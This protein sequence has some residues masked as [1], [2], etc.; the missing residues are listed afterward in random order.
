MFSCTKFHPTKYKTM[1]FL[2]ILLATNVSPVIADGFWSISCSTQGTSSWTTN[3]ADVIGP[4]ISYPNAVT[5]P[6]YTDLN[7]NSG[8]AY[9]YVVTA[10]NIS[11]ESKFSSEV[12]AVP[13]TIAPGFPPADDA[14]FISQSVPSNMTA[15]QTYN[16][17]V[18]VGN[19]GSSTWLAGGKYQLASQNPA[20]NAVWSVAPDGSQ[21]KGNSI[22]SS[23][24]VGINSDITFSFAVTAPSTPGTYNF[25]W[26]MA[27]ETGASYQYFGEQTDNVVITVGPAVA[28]HLT[29]AQA[30][31][32]AQAFCNSNGNPISVPGNAQYAVPDAADAYWQPCWT[33]TFDGQATVEVVDATSIVA[34]YMNDAYSG[35]LASIRQQ[36]AGP[37][38]SQNTAVQTAAAA[39]STTANVDQTGQVTAY[40]SQDNDG[41]HAGESTWNILYPRQFQGLPYKDDVVVM[42]IDAATNKLMGLSLTYRCVPPDNGG[43]AMVVTQAQANATAQSQINQSGIQAPLLQ[44]SIVQVVLPNTYWQDGNYNFTPGQG[45]VAWVVTYSLG[46]PTLG[47]TVGVWVDAATGNIIGGEYIG[48][49]LSRHIN[50]K[51]ATV[52]KKKAITKPPRKPKN[53]TSKRSNKTSQST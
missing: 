36:L 18:T 42:E 32:I 13:I 21:G 15:G 38:V 10:V 16:V 19:A 28:T 29:P 37:L 24:T 22:S 26:Q 11:G 4:Q 9:Y 41:T 40:L 52:H 49:E 30:V 33:V 47:E 14:M 48:G 50:H 12:V 45:K 2:F 5:G 35:Y 51:P 27:N 17:T 3:L 23:T 7:L 31:Q 34:S 6:H 25:Q 46:D 53:K 43:S 44:G 39:L 20:G 8:T 1:L